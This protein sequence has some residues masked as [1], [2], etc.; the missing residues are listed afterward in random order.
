MEERSSINFIHSLNFTT[1]TKQDLNKNQQRRFWI[2]T[3]SNNKEINW[4][5]DT[6][7]HDISYHDAQHNT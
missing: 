7:S 6:S 4:L 2:Q 1:V 5:A 3:T